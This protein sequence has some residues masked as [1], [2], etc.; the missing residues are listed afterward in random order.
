MWLVLGLLALVLGVEG[1]TCRYVLSPLT[2]TASGYQYN[3]KKSVTSSASSNSYIVTGTLDFQTNFYTLATEIS[4]GINSAITTLRASQY[5]IRP[6]HL[7]LNPTIGPFSNFNG[8]DNSFLFYGFAG[9]SLYGINRNLTLGTNVF[10]SGLGLYAVVNGYAE[11]TQPE[12]NN[13]TTLIQA[14]PRVLLLTDT[15]NHILRSI[16][17]DS[18]STML[19]SGIAQITGEPGSIPSYPLLDATYNEPSGLS[20]TGD[21]SH[22]F[23]SDTKNNCVRVIHPFQY[24][25]TSVNPS[26]VYEAKVSTSLTNPTALTWDDATQAIYLIAND[27]YVLILRPISTI[28]PFLSFRA[29]TLIYTRTSVY[30]PLF[31]ESLSF[32]V[33]DGAVDSFFLSGIGYSF[34]LKRLCSLNSTCQGGYF[35][36]DIN[37]DTDFP[38]MLPCT[39]GNYCPSGSASPTICP[40]NTY[41]SSRGLTQGNIDSCISCP[42]G[43]VNQPKPLKGADSISVCIGCVSGTYADP[44]LAPCQDCPPGTFSSTLKATSCTDC[45]VGYFSPQKSTSCSAYCKAGTF[46]LGQG[47]YPCPLGFY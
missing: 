38:L 22:V 35:C 13:P 33:K 31:L 17:L 11:G 46:S 42:P 6:P 21:K 44:A 2:S 47:C 32:I 29:S 18:Q 1:D 39:V 28:P 19:Y 40:V 36:P 9:S 5:Q 37:T 45:Q 20:I 4:I 30:S 14:G 23:V 26:L 24:P 7:P 43:Y 27:Y 8:S 15:G 34:Y 12:F 16:D 41:S 10:D 3:I 25:V